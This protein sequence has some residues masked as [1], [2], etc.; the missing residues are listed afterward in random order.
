MFIFYLIVIFPLCLIVIGISAVRLMFKNKAAGDKRREKYF[1]NL[2]KEL[3]REKRQ[4][5]AAR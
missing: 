2:K 1:E 5:K 3:A 4:L